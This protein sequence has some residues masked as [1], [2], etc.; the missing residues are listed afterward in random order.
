MVHAL[1]SIPYIRLQFVLILGILVATN[2][3]FSWLYPLY[4]H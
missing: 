4:A 1:F 3:A 2:P